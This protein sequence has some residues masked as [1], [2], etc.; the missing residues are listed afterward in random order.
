MEYIHWICQAKHC[1]YLP[2][3]ESSLPSCPDCP[4]ELK[5]S[6]CPKSSY[7]E[8]Y[9]Q[10][11]LRRRS[12]TRQ[13][14][15]QQVNRLT[16]NTRFTGKAGSLRQPVVDPL[17]HNQSEMPRYY[18]LLVRS[19]GNFARKARLIEQP[20]ASPLHCTQPAFICSHHHTALWEKLDQ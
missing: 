12:C 4:D 14:L 5:W 15:S 10:Y 19:S 2:N 17:S 7:S 16:K 3:N 1:H 20:E 13:D 9:S 18:L 11:S 8:V 6:L